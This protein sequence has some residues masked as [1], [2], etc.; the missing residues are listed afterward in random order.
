MRKIILS[1]IL[2]MPF[3]GMAQNVP[4]GNFEN[5]EFYGWGYNPENWVTGNTQLTEPVIQ[6]TDSYEGD[7][8]MQVHAIPNGLGL[9]AEATTDFE[10]NNIPEVLNFYTKYYCENGGVAVEIFFYDDS[11]LISSSSWYGSDTLDTYGFV[12]IPLEPMDLIINHAVIKV[13][14][15]VGDFAPGSARILV[16][17]MDFGF[18]TSVDEE[19]KKSFSVYPNPA[20]KTVNLS[21][22]YS[23]GKLI[24]YDAAGRKV[25]SENVSQ[26]E[27]QIDISSLKPGV[28][29]LF[30]ESGTQKLIVK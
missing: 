23:I 29:T 12:S 13:S 20:D 26:N 3:I 16:D 1:F 10:I 2:L 30:S 25:L 27:V 6:D 24:F 17:Q 11:I 22:E 15:S 5:W 4:N 28:Y 19:K 9:Y 14:A 18:H 8:A 7:F 21:S